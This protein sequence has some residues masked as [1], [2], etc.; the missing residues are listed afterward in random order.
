MYSG[1]R[2]YYHI[3]SARFSFKE[4]VPNIDD[5]QQF[6]GITGEEPSMADFMMQLYIF[7][8]EDNKL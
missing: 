1:I 8:E 3:I 6:D 2:V 4:T 5:E 7:T